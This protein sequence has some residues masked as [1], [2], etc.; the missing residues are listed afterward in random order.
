MLVIRQQESWTAFFYGY[1]WEFFY[2]YVCSWWSEVVVQC[3]ESTPSSFLIMKTKTR[4]VVVVVWNPVLSQSA[5]FIQLKWL[6]IPFPPFVVSDIRIWYSH[7]MKKLL[8]CSA[9][10]SIWLVITTKAEVVSAG[11]DFYL[12][13]WEEKEPEHFVSEMSVLIPLQHFRFELKR[14][15]CCCCIC[16]V[17]SFLASVAVS[18]AKVTIWPILP[19]SMKTIPIWHFIYPRPSM[20]PRVCIFCNVQLNI[21]FYNED[22]CNHLL[23]PNV[24]HLEGAF[25]DPIFRWGKYVPCHYNFSLKRRRYIS[26]QFESI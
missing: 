4:F 1:V 2:G 26:G 16:L 8:I 13:M 25:K 19:F 22:I 5:V 7:L 14:S 10:H 11:C 17:S 20:W 15:C 24:Q 3:V 23:R 9:L 18:R 12:F 6:I 21:R